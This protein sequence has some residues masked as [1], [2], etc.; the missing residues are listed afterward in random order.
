MRGDQLRFSTGNVSAVVAKAAITDHGKAGADWIGQL[1]G[2]PGHAAGVLRLTAVAKPCVDG[3]TGMTY[4]FTARVEVA[5]QRYAGCAA[6]AGQG[7]G[8]RS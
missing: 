1:A 7:L 2:G 3:P 6:L 8:P 5:G 4:P